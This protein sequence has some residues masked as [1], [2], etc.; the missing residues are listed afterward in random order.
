MLIQ[1]HL[2]QLA[3]INEEHLFAFRNGAVLA[4]ENLKKQNNNCITDFLAA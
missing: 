2:F 3:D 4:I 1:Q